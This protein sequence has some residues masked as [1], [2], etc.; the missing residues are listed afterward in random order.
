MANELYQDRDVLKHYL[1]EIGTI[2][3]LTREEEIKY[4]T[5]A[6]KGSRLARETLIKS[7]L[8][9]VVK[10]ALDYSG[11]GLPLADLI[12][13]GNIG[14][15]RAAELFDPNVGAKFSTYS[16]LWIKQRIRRAI[17][18]QART[19]RVPIWRSQLYRRVQLA[20]EALTME[21]GRA[22]SEEELIEDGGFNREDLNRAREGTVQ[23]VSLDAPIGDDESES[24]SLSN[25]I[26][27]DS[28]VDPALEIER[29]EMLENALASLNVL[30]DKELKILA[31]RF[32]L[33]GRDEQTLETIGK[34]FKVSRERIRQLQ[35]IA[36]TKLRRAFLVQKNSSAGRDEAYRQVYAR[37]GHLLESP[38]SVSSKADEASVAPQAPARKRH[39]RR[40]P[41]KGKVQAART[42]PKKVHMSLVG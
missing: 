36:L 14:L 23:V 24:T 41:G 34:D 4:A 19:V 28:A 1:A 38:A 3:L 27:D 21:L 12:S 35:E 26:A 10:I 29:R 13:E 16:S 22:P 31:L 33:N 32:G 2:P 37:L 40:S 15:I 8:R 17:S 25:R 6:R 18:N 5:Q 20:N 11:M 39:A 30:N 7:N 9:L 42:T